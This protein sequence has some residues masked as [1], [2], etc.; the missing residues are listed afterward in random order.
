MQRSRVCN[1]QVQLDT[2]SGKQAKV[3]GVAVDTER[4]REKIKSHSIMWVL[5]KLILAVVLISQLVAGTVINVDKQHGISNISCCPSSSESAATPCKTLTLAL[6]CVQNISLTTPVSLIV[7]EGEYTLTNDSRLTVIE[8]R[9]G[10]FAITG[11]CSTAGPCVEIDCETGA[12]LS[13]IKSDG[14]KLENFVITGCGFPNNSTSKD[15]SSDYFQ[16]VT[17]TLYFLLCRTVTISHV[18]VQETEGTGVVMYSTVGVNTITNSNFASNNPL[19]LND[20]ETISGGGGVYIEFAYCYPGNTSCFDG[21][22]NI[23]D[24]YTRDS[25]YTI[26]DC[27]FSDNFA[28]VQ[29]THQYTYILP[30]KSNH[31]A[32]GRGGGLSLFFKGYATNNNINIESS[33]FT[34]NSALWGAGLFV[35]MQ[36][37]SSNN[38]VSVS[39]SALSG[40]ECLFKESSSQGTGGGGTRIGYLFFNDTHVKS[41]SIVFENCHFSRNSAYFGG[42]L[43]FYAAREPIE[44]SPTNSLVFHS[45][46][47]EENIARAGSGVDLSVWHSE[48]YGST[49]RVVF[50]NCSFLRNTGFY[51]TNQSKIVGIGALYIDSIPVYF[52]DD[53]F[54]LGNNH[55]ALAAI[56][57][58]I[59]IMTNSS[60]T[61]RNNMGRHG[62]AIAL[63]GA[64]FIETHPLSKLVFVNNSALIAGGAIYEISIGEHDLINSRNCFIR[65]FN[66]SVT[67]DQW[68]SS[69]FFSGN[70]ANER[71]ESIFASS[72]LICQWGGAYGNTSDNFSQVFCWSDKNWDYDGGN[73]TTEVRTSPAK[74]S[75]ASHYKI[76]TYPGERHN[77]N[78]TMIDDHGSDVTS[79]SVF[80]AKS[81]ST[82]IQLDS[83][84][85]YIS[86][87]H[88]EVHTSNAR[89]DT[90]ISGLFLLETID[91]RVIQ[92]VLNV[93]VF[94]CPPGMVL[95]GGSNS[96]SCQCGGTFDGKLEC[97]ATGFRTKIERGNWI[98]VYHH[99]NVSKVV[100]GSTPYIDTAASDS[101]IELPRKTKDLN[102][103][104]CENIKR[105][106]TLCGNCVDG[107]G[108]TIHTLECVRCDA[109]YMWALY[110]LSQFLPLTLLFVLV[111]VLDIRVTS[112]PANAFIFFAQVLPTVFT[113][114]GGGAITL[115]HTSGHLVKSY[116]F[117][118]NIWNLQFFTLGIC[119][120]P[121][122]S[123]LVAISITYLEAAYPL[124]LIGIVALFVWLYERGYRCIVCLCR[125]FH[126]L[127]ARFQHHWNIERSLIHAFATF[128]LLSYSRFIQVSFKLLTT[129]QLIRDDKKQFGPPFGVVFYD[130]NIEYLSAEHA[131]F[132]ILS[133]L[134]LLSFVLVTPLLLIVPSLARNLGIIRNRWPR[135]NRLLPNIINQYTIQHWPKLNVFLE[136]FHGCYRD[137]TNTTRNSTEFDYRWVAGF[138]L[139]LRVAL[140]AV[141]AFTPNLFVQY[142][143]LQ[144]FCTAALLVFVVLQPY[145]KRFYNKLDAT[146]FALLLSINTLTMFNYSMTVVSSQ[147]SSFAFCL[148]YALVLLPLIY[149]SVVVLRQFYRYCTKR[150]YC[151]RTIVSDPEQ[152]E[153]L[154]DEDEGP[155]TQSGARDYLSFMRETG[156]LDQR[157]TYRPASATDTSEHSE[158]T[159]SDKDSGNGGTRSTISPGPYPTSPTA[160]DEMEGKNSDE[161]ES[162]PPSQRRRSS[163]RLSSGRRLGRDGKGSKVEKDKHGS[164]Q[165]G[166][167][168][169]SAKCGKRRF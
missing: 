55:S 17:S 63:L 25:T 152:E 168:V 40:N 115:S 80:L 13:F 143:F 105:N 150:R 7:S 167:G 147:S 121:D 75:T 42:G 93:T 104:L 86:D 33:N 27:L 126:I 101:F 125:P 122:V 144:L 159:S 94:P 111:I 90:E 38:N 163:G 100:A 139:V 45:A 11:N 107:Y 91:P 65:Y 6:E 142:P 57:T 130:G 166:Y 74:F 92:V 50:T 132:V 58:G 156:R 165:A 16:E 112:A 82:S 20:S 118:Y 54:F 61:F 41:N 35:E 106:G 53:N 85:Q 67:P 22:P 110:L 161:F 133:L 99:R 31:I 62:G 2:V 70:R 138:Y 78:F 84:S 12:G 129:A 87:N 113:L 77:M 60:V 10:G 34:N 15:F 39:N 69:F 89:D 127:L 48:P 140:F 157:N 137:G 114:D 26:S 119:L 123:T 117:L 128:I 120:S 145:K 51:T 72:L 36:D 3:S 98:G 160:A 131:P 153:L 158:P 73:C 59:H 68:N 66:I 19:T 23:P 1:F 108:P 79:S 32:S 97:N 43:S 76:K 151:R 141:F 88:I 134:V 52:T 37:W 28:S 71:N 146:M 162:L 47:W 64:A 46:T 30:Q 95:V 135:L 124:A 83:S 49:V 9:T 149:I 24:D 56:S 21:P 44:S 155:M 5:L 81:L 116:S 148:Q 8:E 14:I 154:C 136:T 103:F 29:D 109:D 169:D 96:A 4:Q 102:K 18:T 164:L